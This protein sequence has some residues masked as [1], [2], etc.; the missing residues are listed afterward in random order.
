MICWCIVFLVSVPS[1]PQNVT[2]S[3]LTASTVSVQW[4]VPSE[5]HGN[6]SEIIYAINWAGSSPPSNGTVWIRE[7]G[8]GK[9]LTAAVQGLSDSQIYEFKVVETFWQS[10]CYL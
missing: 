2:V 1:S 3:V 7:P 8:R 6:L 10:C 9:F 5:P 4:Q